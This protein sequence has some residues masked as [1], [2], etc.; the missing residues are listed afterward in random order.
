M[1]AG[2]EARLH[3]D[4]VTFEARDAD[5]LRAVDSEGSL[6]AAAAAL[7]RSYSRSHERL[8][9]LEGAFGPLVERTRGGSG[10]GGS[11]L[12]DRARALLARFDRLRA[13][14]SGVAAG[15]ETVLEGEVLGRTGELATVRTGV[16]ELRALAP[17]GAEAVQV[18]LRA[19]AVTLHDPDE[20]PP[21]G[22]TSARNRLAGTVDGV[23][24]GEAVAR[25]AV[26]VGATDPLV[27]LVTVESLERLDLRPGRP[28]VATF[29]ATATRA[30]ER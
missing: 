16:G 1:D 22:G 25:V 29:K 20:A 3:A 12:T 27:A 26:D 28:V 18:T 5:L 7:E 24:A 6:N 9:D 13:E 19:D 4:G 11:R 10:G 8:G 17:D 15:A 23:D 30:V 2:F 14:Y 21:A